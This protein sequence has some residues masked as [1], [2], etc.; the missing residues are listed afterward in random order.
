MLAHST[1][2]SPEGAPK[3]MRIGLISDTH[4]FLDPRVSSIFRGVDHILHA[5]DIGPAS[6]LDA[7]EDI[8]PV[9]AVYGNTD[10]GLSVSETEVLQLADRK[11]LLHHIVDPRA[12]DDRLQRRLAR[13]TP[14]IVV[15]GH[16]HRPLA[17]TIDKITYWNPGYAGKQRFQLPRS[18]AIA[19]AP[20][21]GGNEW[22]I[23]FVSL[24]P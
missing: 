14:D 16:T 24:S 8:A 20:A 9:T 13:D 6:L 22:R 21:G 18:V 17:E 7:L 5:G 10:E 15:Y 23:E 3:K 2:S 12:P 4:G 1:A 11:F 19:E